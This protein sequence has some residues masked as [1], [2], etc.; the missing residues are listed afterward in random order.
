MP[1]GVTVSLVAVMRVEVLAGLAWQAW[2][3]H[4]REDVEGREGAPRNTLRVAW[5]LRACWLGAGCPQNEV[6]GALGRDAWDL[7]LRLTG[8]SDGLFLL[9]HLPLED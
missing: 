2:H 4:G 6:D 7:G 3:R 9:Q 1:V 8:F 5:S